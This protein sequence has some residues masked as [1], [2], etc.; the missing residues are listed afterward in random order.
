[1]EFQRQAARAL[2]IGSALLMFAL[3][4]FGTDE[5]PAR[6]L[7]ELQQRLKSRV[8]RPEYAAAIWGA[9][10]ISLDNGKTLFEY[11]SEKLFS[12]ASN[13]KLYTVAAALGRLGPDYR[14]KTS[15]Y[16][17]VRPNRSG[18]LKADLIVYG[19]GDPTINAR[20]HDGDIY[21]ALDPLVRTLTNA[22]VKKIKGDLVGDESF[23]HGP[24]FGSGWHGM[25]WNTTT[26]QKSRP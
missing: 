4:A 15:L 19:R 10:V 9:K 1:M 14:I 12:P 5:A 6:T 23:L 21:L 16:A 26:G 2:L 17:K 18:T 24:E 22:G 3:V 25:I 13:C 11:N 20:L 8:S 7:A